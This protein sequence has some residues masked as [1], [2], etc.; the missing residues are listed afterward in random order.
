LRTTLDWSYALLNPA[1]QYLFRILA[2]F[3]G[4]STLEAIQVVAANELKQTSVLNIM[5]SLIDKNLLRQQEGIPGLSRY[6]MLETIRE[7][8]LERLQEQGEEAIA[9]Q[10]HA[11]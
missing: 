7:Y 10:R 8:A 11:A 1:E 3:K 6:F 4:G 9:R 5:E 2:V